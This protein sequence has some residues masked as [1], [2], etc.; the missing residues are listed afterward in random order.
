[1][2]APLG[3]TPVILG[4][5]PLGSAWLATYAELSSCDYGDYYAVILTFTVIII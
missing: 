3:Q 4:W 2:A 5:G 1:M